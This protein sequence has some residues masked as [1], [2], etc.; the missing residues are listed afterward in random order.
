MHFYLRCRARK[1][2][3]L[4]CHP[5][6]NR[7]LKR[8]GCPAPRWE[9]PHSS[10]AAIRSGHFMQTILTSAPLL[11]C[12]GFHLRRSPTQDGLPT[13]SLHWSKR[14][15]HSLMIN[16]WRAFGPSAQ[17]RN[18]MTTNRIPIMSPKSAITVTSCLVRC[19]ASHSFES[20]FA[21]NAARQPSTSAKNVLGRSWGLAR[22]PG[23]PTSVRTGRPSALPRTYPVALA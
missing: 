15:P 5:M 17:L 9:N 18:T 23:W 13:I 22:K 14:L 1:I 12:F 19:R 7:F 20:P 10:P 3:S 2:C 21:S 16:L 4:P 11:V 6:S 8:R